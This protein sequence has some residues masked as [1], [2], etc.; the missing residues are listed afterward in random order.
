M[1]S[2]LQQY[3]KVCCVVVISGHGIMPTT[4]HDGVLC[5]SY[6]CGHGIILTTIREG[7][8]CCSY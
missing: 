2:C 3:V 6:Q 1:E 8:L 4:I 7:V 5:C